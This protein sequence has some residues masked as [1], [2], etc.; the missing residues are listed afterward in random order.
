MQVDRMLDLEKDG[1]A[2]QFDTSLPYLVNLNEDP[3][4]SEQL[5]YYLKPGHVYVGSADT[6]G[7]RAESYVHLCLLA[8]SSMIIFEL[9]CGCCL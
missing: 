1:V 7:M 6:Q 4:M 3:S 9:N 2:V 5:I 8:R